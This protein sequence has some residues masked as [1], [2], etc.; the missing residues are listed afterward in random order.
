VK[1]QDLFE[2]FKNSA[3]QID[4]KVYSV[5]EITSEIKNLLIRNFGMEPFW[6]KGEISNYK[7]RNSQGHIYFRLKDE[8]S[9][10]NAAF[11]SYANKRML[12][13]LEEGMQVFVSGKIGLYEPHGSYQIIVEEIRP[14]GLGELYARFLQLKKKLEAEGLFDP[15]RKKKIPEL[16]EIIGIITSPTGAA[17]QDMIRIIKN[18]LPSTSII[19]FPVRVQGEDA[20]FDIEAA[21]EL[22]NRKEFEIDV[23]ILG[24]GGGSI[25]EL[26][27]FNEEIVAR[28]ISES[29][30]PVISAV[31]HETDF[32]ISDFV[33]DLRAATPSNAAE[34]VVPEKRE[35]RHRIGTMVE[36]I[37]YQLNERIGIYSERIKGILRSAALH[38]PMNILRTR[39]QRLSELT[40]IASNALKLKTERSLRR[41]STLKET[42]LSRTRLLLKSQEIRIKSLDSTLTALSPLAVLGRGYAIARKSSGKIIKSYKDVEVG[43]DLSLTLHE[44]TVRTKV[45]DKT[46]EKIK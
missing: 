23:I 39:Q 42:F 17:V 7:G 18:R 11:F 34:L 20:K 25:E 36:S 22:A 46:E 38:D 9:L 1:D 13:E 31:G 30:I 2:Y 44:G 14:A 29:K 8:K 21:L 15:D 43:Q 12:F 24:R 41:F 45:T 16:P 40:D 33:A 3:P 28:A 19:I 5:S 6:I 27:A 26:W 10:I 35:L 37:F 32:T 4:G